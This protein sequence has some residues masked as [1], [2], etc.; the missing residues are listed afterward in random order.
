MME[1]GRPWERPSSGPA[2]WHVDGDDATLAAAVR[3]L[4][5]ARVEF[6][7]GPGSDLARA[8][9]V[10][11]SGGDAWEVGLDALR[12]VADGREFFGVNMVV[13]G[14][15]PDRATWFTSAPALRVRV[16]DRVV[17]DAPATAVVVASGQYLRGADLVPRGHPGDGR[18]EVQVYA[19]GRGE[20]A[21]VRSRLP[22]GIH[23]PHPDITQT[24]GRQVEIR[25][26]RGE[27]P[28]EIDGVTLPP[29]ALVTVEVLPEAFVLVL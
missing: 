6:R 16:G 9:G 4:P 24:S 27:L 10:R 20:R 11:S 14:V 21:G 5:G 22:Q 17:H 8:L 12:V 13:V 7:P 3:D 19:V 29:A 18:A 26:D 23:L 2:E 28:L 15:A 25:A 1:K